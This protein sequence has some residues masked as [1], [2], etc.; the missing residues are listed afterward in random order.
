MVFGEPVA[1][2]AFA[3]GGALVIA[4]G[5]VQGT[6]LGIVELVSSPGGGFHACR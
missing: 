4:P 2:R 6:L 1:G 5:G 3:E